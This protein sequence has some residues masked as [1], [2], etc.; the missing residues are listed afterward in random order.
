MDP[1]Q[2]KQMFDLEFSLGS[3]SIESQSE[4]IS[5]WDK[6]IQY[7]PHLSHPFYLD[8][9]GLDPIGII[10][11]WLGT[12]MSVPVRTFLS[13]GVFELMEQEVCEI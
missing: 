3:E 4:M 8:R 5:L 13:A 9:G 1:T 2:L 7:S 12:L 11:D 10:A 6:V